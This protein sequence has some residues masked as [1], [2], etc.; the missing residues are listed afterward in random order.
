MLC[1]I[2][3]T[4]NWRLSAIDSEIK[5]VQTY[6]RIN[7]LIIYPKFKLLPDKLQF[8]H[9]KNDVPVNDFSHAAAFAQCHRGSKLRMQ[10]KGNNKKRGDEET[11]KNR[12]FI[13]SANNLRKRECIMRKLWVMFLAALLTAVFAASAMAGPVKSDNFVEGLNLGS[14]L[15]ITVGSTNINGVGEDGLDAAYSLAGM[16][17]NNSIAALGDVKISGGFCIYCNEGSGNVSGKTFIIPFAAASADKLPKNYK[18][19]IAKQVGATSE[20]DPDYKIFTGVKVAASASHVVKEDNKDVAVLTVNF[21]EDYTFTKGS[22]NI[23]WIYFIE[24]STPS[25]TVD[26]TGVTLNKTALLLAKGNSAV[27]TAT[28]APANATN[29]S[30]T[31]VSSSADVVSVDKNGKVTALKSGQETITV[32]TADGG[33]TAACMVIITEPAA[34]EDIHEAAPKYADTAMSADIVGATDFTSAD[35]A[36]EDGKLVLSKTLQDKA[37]VSAASQDTALKGGS[38]KIFP[39]ISND[40]TSGEIAAVKYTVKGD[41]FGVS[42]VSDMKVYKIFANGAATPFAIITSEDQRGDMTAALYKSGN[43]VTG[44]IDKTAE[45]TLITYVKD[46]GAFDLDEDANGT[47][48]DPIAIAKA[49]PASPVTDSGSSSG[50]SAGFGVMALLAL[51]ALPILRKKK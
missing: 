5:R 10:A 3:Y 48:V 46:G 42:A 13:K 9:Y 37:L 45:Y 35:I 21:A 14:G 31:W 17:K 12:G 11:T 29:K 25:P 50:C 49:A 26:V 19:A 22:G 24:G 34:S 4:S 33:K 15:Q 38:L 39:I 32:T 44:S 43:I 40:V 27:L 16:L 30:V 36:V 18:I 6:I 1:I 8:A 2:G 23:Y 28:I 7:L 47:V 20:S 41:L 51:A